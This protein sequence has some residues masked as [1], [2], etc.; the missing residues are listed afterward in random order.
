M[1]T[2]EILQNGNWKSKFKEN[3]LIVTIDDS[4]KAKL[5]NVFFFYQFQSKNLLLQWLH[6]MQ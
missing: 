2:R 1:G 6:V 3:R 5:L 4:E